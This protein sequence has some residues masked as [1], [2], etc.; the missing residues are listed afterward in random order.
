MKIPHENAQNTGLNRRHFLKTTALLGTVL[1]VELTLPGCATTAH[2]TANP[3]DWEPD[4]WLSLDQ[5]GQ[6]T[7][8]L[9]SVEMG[10]GTM[11]G[12]TTLVAEELNVAP[13]S[14]K[15]V[16]DSETW[17][18]FIAGERNLVWALLTRRI[19]L[20]GNPKW[21]LAFKRCFPS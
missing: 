2:V 20:R 14:I 12:L 9:A 15:V 1:V 11:T 6:I 13:A 19:R 5:Q 16:A 8:V 7:F 10:Q 4:A 18:G 17:L 21:L 3:S